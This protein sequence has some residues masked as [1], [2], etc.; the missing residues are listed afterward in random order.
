MQRLLWSLALLVLSVAAVPSQAAEPAPATPAAAPPVNPKAI[1]FRF[2]EVELYDLVNFLAKLDQHVVLMDEKVKG[3]VSVAAPKPVTLEEAYG[4]VMAVLDVRGF[5]LVRSDKFLRVQP[6]QESLY[7]PIDV[8][9]GREPSAIPDEARMVTALIPISQAKASAVSDSLRPLISPVGNSEINVGT[10]LLIITDVAANLRRLLKI[11]PYLDKPEQSAATGKSPAAQRTE[12]YVIKYLVAKEIAEILSKVHSG[13]DESRAASA[14]AA[15]ATGG[16]NGYLFVAVEPVNTV[17]VTADDEGHRQIAATLAKLDIRRRQVL[18]E[19]RIIEFGRDK[20]LDVGVDVN[21]KDIDKAA[22]GDIINSS[23]TWGTGLIGKTPQ[24]TF[25]KL[26]KDKGSVEVAL[27]FLAEKNLVRII[28]T[29]KILTADN[30][31]AKLTSGTEEP[32]LKSTTDLSTDGGGT[33]KTVSDYIYKDV[34]YELSI[35][36]HINVERDVSL[37]VN[38]HVSSILGEK[39]FGDVTAPRMGKREVSANVTIMDGHTLVIGGLVSSDKLLTHTGVPYLMDIPWLGALF[40]RDVTHDRESEILVFLTP[41][42][43]E[44][45]AE[46]EALTQSQSATLKKR[47]KTADLKTAEQLG[48]IRDAAEKR[49]DQE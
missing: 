2:H 49:Q 13:R 27:A 35:T 38:F 19:A 29:P 44:T 14:A 46:G 15:P 39:D 37:D 28:A 33:P 25:Q 1:T 10:N 40:S 11:V 43:V 17:L 42:V 7:A 36:P 32:I 24:Y 4:I 12:A 6:K 41:H 20:D 23:I 47:I 8:F 18:I 34:G 21:I 9:F 31:K 22:N 16:R 26:F 3:K 48:E 30:Q 5:N 45:A